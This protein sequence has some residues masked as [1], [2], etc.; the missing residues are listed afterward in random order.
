MA[1]LDN[2]NTPEWREQYLSGGV[3]GYRPKFIT[4]KEAKAERAKP[5][6]G[7][8]IAQPYNVRKEI[9]DV[10]KNIDKFEKMRL[11][12]LANQNKISD[13]EVANLSQS[14][15]I[16]ELRKRIHLEDEEKEDLVRGLELAIRNAESDGT[17]K[18]SWRFKKLKKKIGG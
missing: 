14:V 3:M 5:V 4:R 2:M 15:Q 8:R 12:L 17:L 16:K 10:E 18:L 11:K 9:G 13:L 6:L 1:T 7:D